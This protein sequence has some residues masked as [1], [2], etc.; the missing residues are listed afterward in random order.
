MTI[1]WL[2]PLD[3]GGL[4]ILDYTVEKKE[5]SKKAWQKVRLPLHFKIYLLISKVLKGRAKKLSLI[6]S[7]LIFYLIDLKF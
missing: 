1:K 4:D 5:T 6:K 7:C 3:D 2:P